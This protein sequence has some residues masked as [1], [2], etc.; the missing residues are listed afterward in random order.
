MNS[1]RVKI[2]A[3]SGAIVAA[4]SV[5][6]RAQQSDR[7]AEFLLGEMRHPCRCLACRPAACQRP[8]APRSADVDRGLYTQV[9]QRHSSYPAHPRVR[10]VTEFNRLPQSCY[11]LLPMAPTPSRRALAL[12]CLI[13]A[14]CA[15]VHP[16]ALAPL[17]VG[18]TGD[19]A[20]FSMSHDGHFTGLD[21]DIVDRLG[22][23]LALAPTLVPFRWPDLFDDIRNASF[24]LA[25]SGITMRPERAVVGRY[26]RPYAVAGA[27]AIIR[28]TEDPGFTDITQLDDPGVR[29]AVNAGGH[30]ERVA[31]AQF[32]LAL[33]IPIPNNADV[34]R[35]VLEGSADA[36][37]SDSAEAA[38][39][40][41]PKLRIIGP[42]THDH[43]ALLFPAGSQVLASRVDAWLVAREQDGWLPDT[44]EKWL[45]R[46]ARSD[47]DDMTR[48]AVAAL[49]NLRLGVMPAVGAAKRTAGL[50]IEDP[51]QEQRVLARVS[52]GSPDPAR[53]VAVYR[54]L[55][56][57]AKTVE[58]ATPDELPT[59]AL[60][61]L[62]AA[63]GR[64]DEQLARELTRTPPTST[65][66]WTFFLER[67]WTV[68]G[69]D[70]TSTSRLATA[71]ASPGTL[72]ANIGASAAD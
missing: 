52:A 48:E 32:P 13:V 28:Q 46:D 4:L 11:V 63:I 66:E 14:G 38:H 24:D 5:G 60:P 70:L 3:L 41:T 23:D 17:R 31:H 35:A 68:P 56:D 72:N 42:F 58:F 53:T 65:T 64:I 10:G 51:E 22:H 9:G 40:L 34:P 37:I 69:I 18:T 43:K 33:I 36:A 54:V 26:S 61:D 29:I 21:I 7:L 15:V 19:Y 1:R 67:T 6:I 16:A 30:L 2:F 27:V 55:I 71:L 47:A 49:I 20:P 62:R 12:A 59:A 45:G 57:M 25:A 50:P 39:W 8:Q 44:R